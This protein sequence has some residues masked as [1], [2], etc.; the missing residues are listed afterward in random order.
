MLRSADGAIPFVGGA[1]DEVLFFNRALSPTEITTY[2]QSRAPYGSH[3]TPGAQ[4]DFDDMRV[5]ETT[6][7]QKEHLTHFE[8]IGARPHSDTDLANVVAYY[9]LDGD[10]K[11]VVGKHDGTLKGTV[12][13]VKGRFGDPQGAI[14]NTGSV[15]IPGSADLLAASGTWEAW[16]EPATCNQSASLLYSGG[17]KTGGGRVFIA[18]EQGCMVRSYFSAG[19]KEWSHNAK[20][21]LVVGRWHHV[22]LRWDSSVVWFYVDGGEVGS[23]AKPVGFGLPGDTFHIGSP[24][25]SQQPFQGAIDE[26]IIH[27]VAKSPDY[28]AKRAHGLPR[29]RFLAHTTADHGKGGAYGFHDYRLYWENP[30]AKAVATK[31][32]GL[33]KK[34]TCDA[35]LSPCLGYAGWWRFHDA[36]PT[37][38]LDSAS[39]RNV[40]TPGA[41][42]ALAPGWQGV[43]GRFAAG[44]DTVTIPHHASLNLGKYTL[45]AAL[46]AQETGTDRGILS[47]GNYPHNYAMSAGWGGDPKLGGLQGW[48]GLGGTG[49]GEIAKAAK[50]VPAGVGTA[51]AITHDGTTLAAF[52][53]YV[54]AGAEPNAKAPPP[55]SGPLTLGG[56]KGDGLAPGF[57]GAIDS[58]RIMARALGTDEFLHYPLASHNLKAIGALSCGATKDKAG[59]SCKA[60]RDAGCVPKDGVYWIDPNGGATDDAFQARC[61]MTTDG[62]G[63]TLAGFR[64]GGV[65]SSQTFVLHG[66]PVAGFGENQ[67]SGSWSLGLANNT[68]NGAAPYIEL[69][70][71]AGSPKPRIGD[72]T[73]KVVFKWDGSYRIQSDWASAY[74]QGTFSWA[75]APGEPLQAGAFVGNG[76]G[77][78]GHCKGYW[79]PSDPKETV[80]PIAMNND[81]WSGWGGANACAPP[82][83]G[84][85]AGYLWVR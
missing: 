67:T 32:V 41:G 49:K 52:A 77:A 51:V 18:L 2:V 53:D 62:G 10:G 19:P 34:T 76:A 16:I 79:F 56:V 46:T 82:M 8:V 3:F 65:K 31:L 84:Q 48:V 85:S 14:S 58:V 5:T 11:D 24:I 68:I 70:V 36:S 7:G 69:A 74:E 61:D 26:V 45:E 12:T 72:W 60:M 47:K 59:L 40:G 38:V 27:N 75:C 37:A 50:V 29:V 33:D 30:A 42:F 35:L 25:S 20:E 55:N 80:M 6:L 66:T 23:L 21:S 17:P 39:A 15:E 9:K 22:A 63:W 73:H 83:P 4:H 71:T 64:G 43:A 57:K 54:Q 78:C 81:Y 13:K 44:A 28:I 1:I